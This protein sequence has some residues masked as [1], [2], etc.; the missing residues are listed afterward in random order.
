MKNK[1]VH[2]LSETSVL[3]DLKKKIVPL[4]DPRQVWKTWL[5]KKIMTHFSARISFIFII[6][7]AFQESKLL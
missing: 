5:A 3:K 2:R 6:N 7:M 4:M 1:P